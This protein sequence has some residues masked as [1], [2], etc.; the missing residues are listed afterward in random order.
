L[1]LQNNNVQELYTDL[2]GNTTTSLKKDSENKADTVRITSNQDLNIRIGTT[3]EA[4]NY[5][6]SLKIGERN[7]KCFNLVNRHSIICESKD[8]LKNMGFNEKQ[9]DLCFEYKNDK[10]P[11]EGLILKENIF[12]NDKLITSISELKKTLGFNNKKSNS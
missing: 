12:V 10:S 6:Y 1:K 2:D 4:K 5:L 7:M 8:V 3:R 11:D 9:I